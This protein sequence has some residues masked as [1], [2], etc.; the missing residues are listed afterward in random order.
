[1]YHTIAAAQLPPYFIH[2]ED[3]PGQ[4]YVRSDNPDAMANLLSR[5]RVAVVGS[6]K[7][8]EYG[9]IVT[10]QLVAELAARGVVIVSGLALGIDAVAHRT[11]LDADGLTMAV[12]PC[13]VEQVYPASHRNLANDILANG[14]ALVSEYPPG[15]PP[16]VHHFLERNRIVSGLSDALLIVEAAEK[17]GTLRTATYALDQGVD[18]MIVPGSILSPTSVGT[19]G[20]MRTGATPVMSITDILHKLNLPSPADDHGQASHAGTGMRGENPQEQLLIDLMEQGISDGNELLQSSGFT[21]QQFNHN[22][23]MLEIAAKVRP[24]GANQWALG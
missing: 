23:T 3:A 2:G 14:G 5:K 18:V 16:L 20:L 15:T 9:N 6:R 7:L 8:S 21:I 19:N 4:L 22:L 10:R 11:A 12:L 13:A 1:M 24:L 17:S